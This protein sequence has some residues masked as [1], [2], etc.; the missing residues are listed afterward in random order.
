MFLFPELSSFE[1][2]G[3]LILSTQYRRLSNISRIYI[4]LTPSLLI[5]GGKDSKAHWANNI[6]VVNCQKRLDNSV[7]RRSLQISAGND[8][9]EDE[10]NRTTF[11]ATLGLPS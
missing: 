2:L 3:Y 1:R 5:F 8:A 6:L 9:A 11:K 10:G 4:G 7:R